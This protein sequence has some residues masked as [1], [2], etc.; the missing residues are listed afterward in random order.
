MPLPATGTDLEIIIL[1]EERERQIPKAITSMQNLKYDTNECIYEI[2]TSSQTQRTDWWLPTGK[3][4]R[5]S[6]IGS[7]EVVHGNYYIYKLD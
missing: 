5:E 7:L 4:S 6:W 3:G 2:E 1:S